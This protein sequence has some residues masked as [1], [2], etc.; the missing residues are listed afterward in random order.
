MIAEFKTRF[1]PS[2]YPLLV[3]CYG[4]QEAGAIQ[5]RIA[6][7]CAEVPIQDT[8]SS[9]LIMTMNASRDTVWR[10]IRPLLPADIAQIRSSVVLTS[11]NQVIVGLLHNALDACA[12]NIN[13]AL[14]YRTGFCRVE[15]NGQGIASIEF[16][17]DG[18]LAKQNCTTLDY[19][20]STVSF[21]PY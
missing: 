4:F 12:D 9:G 1:Q 3:P 7:L 6:S 21:I 10:P 16:R 15:D 2:R 18:G 8:P 19:S 5:L 20:S 14:N 13:V 17:S 11:L